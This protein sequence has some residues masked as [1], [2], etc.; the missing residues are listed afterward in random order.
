MISHDQIP[1]P[2]VDGII[3]HGIVR[4]NQHVNLPNEVLSLR[5]VFGQFEEEEVPRIED[6]EVPPLRSQPLD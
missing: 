4:T 5:L 6:K 2:N 3:A 1:L